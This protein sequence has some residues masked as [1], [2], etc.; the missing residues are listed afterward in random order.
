M[1]KANLARCWRPANAA[2][3]CQSEAGVQAQNKRIGEQAAWLPVADW[4]GAHEVEITE[5]DELSGQSVVLRCAGGALELPDGRWYF[6]D[7][8]PAVLKAKFKQGKKAVKVLG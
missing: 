1:P 5:R 2:G 8:L 4:G 7:V 6:D 3:Q